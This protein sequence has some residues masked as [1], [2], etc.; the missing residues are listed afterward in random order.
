M[1]TL[2]ELLETKRRGLREQKKEFALRVFP[3]A[4]PR[5]AAS[6][7]GQIIN[8][9][10]PLPRSAHAVLAK[11][12]EL[13][14]ESIKTMERGTKAGQAFLLPILTA[15]DLRYLAGVAEATGHGLSP[16]AIAQILLDRSLHKEAG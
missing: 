16:A 13:P 7:Y 10:R 5:G 15:E 14:I 4:T 6:Y 9:N 8:H 11:F 12:L 2:G 3:H 1:T